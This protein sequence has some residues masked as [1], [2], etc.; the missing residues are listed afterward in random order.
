MKTLLICHEGSRI[1]ELGLSRWLASFSDLVG[2]VVIQEKGSKA[3]KRLSYERKRV[4][5]LRLLD[6][7]A[8]RLY[9]KL[10]LAKSDKAAEDKAV[11]ELESR[12]APLR[13]D[14]P[15]L[16]TTSPNSKKARL[17]IEERAPDIVLARCK[18][19][20]KKRVFSIAKTGT[21][22]MHPGIC[23]EYRNSHGCFWALASSDLDKVGMTLLKIDEGI[24][25]GPVYDYYT[26]DFDEIR[27]S[28]VTIQN[29]VV[30]EN[31]DAIAAK[32]EEVYRGDADDI[33]TNGRASGIWGQP[34][35]SK[36]VSW[37]VKARLRSL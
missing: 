30:V 3:L 36:Y 10:A 8:F 20:L 18:L 29:K 31:L 35:L 17:F 2:M 34:W 6:V 26:Y 27:E 22:V 13:K 15:I 32:F 33:S 5:T 23:P 25:T 4:G 11:L 7:A 16:Y 14:L 37:K 12:F 28:H 9:Y 24:D 19:L 21:F 1:T